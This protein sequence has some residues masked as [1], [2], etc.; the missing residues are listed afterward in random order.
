VGPFVLARKDRPLYQM[1][2]LDL[3][4]SSLGYARRRARTGQPVAQKWAFG[5]LTNPTTRGNHISAKSRLP[6]ENTRLRQ[7][8]AEGRDYYLLSPINGA[9]R[10]VQFI[11]HSQ[12]GPSIPSQ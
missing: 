12:H 4:G 7:N 2:S 6:M 10:W 3:D 11:G 5:F 9:A 1:V 8:K